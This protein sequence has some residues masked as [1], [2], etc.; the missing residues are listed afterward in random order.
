MQYYAI[1]PKNN[2][3]Y[4]DYQ[5]A[6]KIN[7]PL[8]RINAPTTLRNYWNILRR[9]TFPNAS[10][11]IF[12]VKICSVTRGTPSIIP[13]P[14]TL[15]FSRYLRHWLHIHT[16]VIFRINCIERAALTELLSVIYQTSTVYFRNMPLCDCQQSG[17]PYC[18]ASQVAPEPLPSKRKAACFTST[19]FFCCCR[20]L[21]SPIRSCDLLNKLFSVSAE[22]S[23]VHVLLGQVISV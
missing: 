14:E 13:A 12:W 22:Q 18:A 10:F 1:C 11:G 19:Y 3:K 2:R 17:A 8:I 21:D 4:F 16:I 15:C 7:R 9:T 20:E 23:L 6:S 5:S